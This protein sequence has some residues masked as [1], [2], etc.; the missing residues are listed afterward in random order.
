MWGGSNLGLHTSFSD[1]SIL[2]TPYFEL[3]V[4]PA[5]GV[6]GTM[7]SVNLAADLLYTEESALAGSSVQMCKQKVHTAVYAVGDV[8]LANNFETKDILQR[9]SVLCVG[10]TISKIIVKQGS[11]VLRETNFATGHCADLCMELEG[12]GTIANRYDVDLDLDDDPTRAMRLDPTKKLSIVATFATAGDVPATCR[13]LAD[14][15]HGHELIQFRSIIC[16]RLPKDINR[17]RQQ[18]A[19]R[20]RFQVPL[21]ILKL[22]PSTLATRSPPV[23]HGASTNYNHPVRCSP[24][25]PNPRGRLK[26]LE[27]LTHSEADTSSDLVIRQQAAFHPIVHRSQ[28]DLQQLGHLLLV[29]SIC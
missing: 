21:V 4:P 1:G 8:E 6:A 25:S 23:H 15:E 7:S 3:D 16:T 11:R 26:I 13:I 9:F 28:G 20:Q 27:H 5:T 29:H 24:P 2:E 19:I 14:C 22:H 10:D 18:F 17:R 12:G